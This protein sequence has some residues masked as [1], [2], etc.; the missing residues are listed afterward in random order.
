MSRNVAGNQ[1]PG[2]NTNIY[3]LTAQSRLRNRGFRLR[4][5]NEPP[6]ETLL[7]R[8]PLYY[9]AFL[10][11]LFSGILRQPLLFVAGLLVL[12]LA[13]IPELWY[14]YC[15]RQLSISRQIDTTRAAL[16]DTVQLS[17][18]IENRKP[19]PLPWF[20]IVDEIPES[21]PVTNRLMTPAAKPERALLTS[22]FSMWAYQ[23]V[24]RR[25]YMRPLARGAYRFGPMT[26]RATDP[27][28]ILTRETTLEGS[29][30]IVV[31]PL[32]VPLERFSLPALAPFGERKAQRRLL[33]D[34]LRIS[35]IRD[36]VPGDEPRRI[37]WKATARMGRLQSKRY[38][39]ST[40]HT[41]AIFLDVR[42]LSQ[43][44]MGYD[45][46]LVELH[47]CAAA[48]VANWAI[49]QG[50]AVGVFANGTLGI[51]ELAEKA[52]GN[53]LPELPET[54]TADERLQREIERTRAGLRMRIPA[55]SRP[56]QLTRILDSLA[57]VLPYYGLPMEQLIL[58]EERELPTGA[59]VVYIGTENLVDVPLIVALR[60]LKSHGHAVSILL[61]QLYQSAEAETEHPL[62][63]V[64][65][66]GLDTHYIGGR[67]TWE[68]LLRETVGQEALRFFQNQQLGSTGHTGN[69]KAGSQQSGAI[70]S[71][72]SPAASDSPYQD[73]HDEQNGDSDGQNTGPVDQAGGGRRSR[74]LVVD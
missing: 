66:T 13:F 26:V 56:E 31:H 7:R 65:L 44:L 17:L 37:H 40:S 34:P 23:R 45:P 48:S 41:L 3:V 12:V 11:I 71:R 54:Q 64:Q 58:A 16:G 14:R 27:F 61:T 5:S 60:R 18:S 62:Q 9:I 20:E 1:T 73:D 21:L 51:P 43:V 25:Y 8:R 47:I 6:D 24:R 38:E 67:V 29:A 74:A 49:E 53:P 46:A 15:L 19:L 36:Y 70:I 57:R 22:T 59:S 68:E 32:V 30:A 50:Y 72:D 10:L 52:Q 39:P 42:T 69:L 33:E 55:S 63:S 2:E 28:G 4:H 35:G